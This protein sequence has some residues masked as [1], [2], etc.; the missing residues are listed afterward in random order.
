[1]DS[2]FRPGQRR[3]AVGRAAA[4]GRAHSPRGAGLQGPRGGD[5]LGVAEPGERRDARSARP[6]RRSDARAAHRARARADAIPRR[7]RVRRARR[8]PPLDEPA[9][10]RHG[11]EPGDDVRRD[12]THLAAGARSLRR[13][14]ADGD[15]PLARAASA[16]RSPR[17]GP[18]SGPGCSSTAPSPPAPC[19]PAPGQLHGI[20]MRL[21]AHRRDGEYIAGAIDASAGRCTAWSSSFFSQSAP[22][23]RGAMRLTLYA[24]PA[25]PLPARDDGA[26]RRL[27]GRDEALVEHVGARQLDPVCARALSLRAGEIELPQTRAA[28]AKVGMERAPRGLRRVHRMTSAWPSCCKRRRLARA[29]PERAH[30]RLLPAS[31]S[32]GRRSGRRQAAGALRAG[33]RGARPGRSTQPVHVRPRRRRPRRRCSPPV[34]GRSGSAPTSP[35]T[36]WGSSTTSATSP[37]STASCRRGSAGGLTH[38]PEAA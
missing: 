11:G 34:G 38:L 9:R 21:A 22:A 30:V 35:C 17:C 15:R 29:L 26:V 31:G 19:R 33:A 18:T 16:P 8:L 37:T 6:R 7:A 23:H 14:H 20:L 3:G 1:M 10:E 27:R 36:V 28:Y 12:P 24:A 25:E 2:L 13:A 32:P 4:Q 5:P